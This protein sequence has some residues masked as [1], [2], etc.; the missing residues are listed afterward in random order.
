MD[1][2]DGKGRTMRVTVATQEGLEFLINRQGRGESRRYD[3][4]CKGP[5]KF[6][7]GITQALSMR[8]RPG[9]LEYL[10]VGAALPPS[11]TGASNPSHRSWSESS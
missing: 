10:L 8:E 1:D 6:N 3:V 9:D 2:E 11:R 5:G 4:L 7:V